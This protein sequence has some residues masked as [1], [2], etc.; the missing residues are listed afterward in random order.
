MSVNEVRI[1][2]Y[3]LAEYLRSALCLVADGR[4]MQM[5]GGERAVGSCGQTKRGPFNAT[6]LRDN[7]ARGEP[8]VSPLTSTQ[9][10]ELCA[11]VRA[12]KHRTFAVIDQFARGVR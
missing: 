2:I 5:C 7:R 1:V 4:R 12:N 11:R 9:V 8:E 10:Q 6:K 3:G